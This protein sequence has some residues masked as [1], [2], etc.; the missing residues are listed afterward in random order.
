[1]DGGV[2]AKTGSAV[3]V[4]NV[5]DVDDNAPV[6]TENTYHMGVAENS[7]VGVVV[8]HVTAVDADLSPYNAVYYAL[9]DSDDSD[10]FSVDRHNGQRQQLTQ[11]RIISSLQTD[12]Q[13]DR[14]TDTVATHLA[15][16]VS[17]RES[18]HEIAGSTN[19]P[20]VIDR[21]ID[22][23][24]ELGGVL[25]VRRGVSSR[26]VMTLALFTLCQYAGQWWIQRR[27][28]GACPPEA[29]RLYGL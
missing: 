10:S 8:G 11:R 6:F 9:I 18:S 25:Y 3:V 16:S 21:L 5:H 17:D 13:T 20:S 24:R 28:R 15:H 23:E 29:H 4:V 7:S 26:P 19:I 1:M 12:R 22:K 27:V 14:Q 2:P